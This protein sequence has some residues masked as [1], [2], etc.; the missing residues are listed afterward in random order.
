MATQAKVI[1]KG[2]N[3]I[4][5][6]VKSAVGDLSSLKTAAD[7]LGSALKGALSVTALIV[8]AKKLSDSLKVCFNDF[9]ESEKAYRQLALAL[10]DSS[11]YDKATALIKNLSRQSTASSSDIE[12]MVTQLAAF[13][14]S[15]EEIEAVSSAAVYLS[16]VTGND[17]NTSMNTLL[18]TYTGR[19]NQLIRMGVDLQNV[20]KEELAHGAAI[21]LVIDKFEAYSK[22]VVD[23]NAAQSLSNIKDTWGD[24]KVQIGGILDYNFGP[25]FAKFDVAFDGI[26]SNIISVVN[27]VGAV[28]KNFPEVFKLTLSTIWELVKRTF[29][30]E[31]IKIIFT[32]AITNIGIVASAMIRATFETIPKMLSAL[33]GG[34]INWIAYIAVNIEASI[35]GAIQN[36]IDKS[37][38]KIQGT[39]FGKLFGLGD[40]LS[41]LDVGA[42]DSASRSDALKLKADQSFE[43]IGPLVKNAIT[44]AIDT[45]TTVGLNTKNAISS[46]Y[47]DIAL[48]FKSALDEIVAPELAIIAERADASN[49][50]KLLSQIASSGTNTADA[51]K[52][53]S[54]N[55]K[56]TRL[57]D[58][59]ATILEDKLNLLM[60][61]LFGGFEG[62]LLGMI[63]EEMLGGVGSIINTLMPLID[64]VFNTLSPLGILLTILEGFV[65]VMEVALSTVFQPLVDV[66]F[67]I[68]ETL[69]KLILPVLD[70]LYSAFSLIA[71]ILTAV[72]SPLLQTF[73]PIFLILSGILQS[74]SPVLLLLAKAFTVLMSPV[75][76]IAD[77]FSWLGKWVQH[78]GNV[79]SIAAYNLLHPFKPKSYGS[80]PGSFSS[81]A[82]SGLS[83]RL[84]N[85]DA[86]ASQGSTVSD[87]VSTSTAVSSAS[88]QG[89]TQVTIN[90]YQQAPVVGNN[91]MR[92]FAQMIRSEFE[93]LDY[94]GVTI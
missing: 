41:S 26:K 50:D 87:S 5:G 90:I 15:S 56:N 62:G 8:A 76:Y 39:W 3:D 85:I 65:S 60:S 58:Q 75:Q 79:V 49:Q 55:T 4:S 10:N 92:A 54:Q 20:T 93:Q 38:A 47:S 32:T 24:I 71:N 42:K 77:L 67:W 40:K 73:Q 70:T 44:D 7:K 30:W 94:F 72:F 48:D 34:I 19:T 25:W 45:A 18:A 78:L 23:D 66:F 2:Q 1:I 91:G 74:I 17:L 11:A 43:S 9:T 35:L 36:V 89:A 29:E 6:A 21:D 68:G 16:N 86:I 61:N 13:G 52:Q 14:K 64:I 28:I 63:A 37:A 82:F 51:T 12:Q 27:Y 80:S 57:A 53:I 31:S 22:M 84:A 46:L 81:D 33:V 69:A 88:Y 83:N 59:I